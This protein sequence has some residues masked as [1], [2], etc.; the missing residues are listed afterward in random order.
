MID[1][2]SRAQQGIRGREG[3]PELKKTF[4]SGAKKPGR[5]LRRKGEGQGANW[6]GD[7]K[8]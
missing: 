6:E 3:L 8:T 5:L 4:V 7:Y 1:R 2:E